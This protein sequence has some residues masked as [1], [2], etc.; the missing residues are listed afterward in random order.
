[1][2]VK[3]EYLEP[4]IY[5]SNWVGNVRIEEALAATKQLM[6]VVTE[7]GDPH[8][9]LIVDLSEM[10][11]LPFDLSNLSRAAKEDSRVADF[12][13]VKPS[14]MAEVLSKMINQLTKLPIH[15]TQ[16]RVEAVEISRSLLQR[17]EQHKTE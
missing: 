6:G 17:A 7:K 11:Q 2:P 16:S 12:V 14:K 1:M 5:C 10:T 4:G 13:I 3:V 8:Y 15:S 9:I